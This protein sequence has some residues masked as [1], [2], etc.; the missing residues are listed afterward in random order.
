[1]ASLSA[2]LCALQALQLVSVLSREVVSHIS[3][4]ANIITDETRNSKI[5]Q[6][7][8]VRMDFPWLGL[9]SSGKYDGKARV[10][11]QVT[12]RIALCDRLQALLLGVWLVSL[13]THRIGDSFPSF[14]WA[15]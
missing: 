15:I 11:S 6:L 10:A 12:D 3:A 7:A 4:R 8:S 14:L 13:S 5:A 2:R 9:D 1:M